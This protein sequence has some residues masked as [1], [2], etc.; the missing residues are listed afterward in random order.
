MSAIFVS[1]PL[2][3][4]KKPHTFPVLYIIHPTGIMVAFSF[5]LFETTYEDF[6][7]CII[8]IIVFIYDLVSPSR[9]KEICGYSHTS[10]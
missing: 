5:A 1:S 8:C 7:N 4:Q 6:E 3:S 2:C 10:H 9:Y